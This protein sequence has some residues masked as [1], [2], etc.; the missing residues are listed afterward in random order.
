MVKAGVGGGFEPGLAHRI[1][2]QVTDKN[3]VVNLSFGYE[4]R[5]G[6]VLTRSSLATA[7]LLRTAAPAVAAPMAAPSGVCSRRHRINPSSGVLL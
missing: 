3:N 1:A 5:P 6:A 2:K 4:R 7:C